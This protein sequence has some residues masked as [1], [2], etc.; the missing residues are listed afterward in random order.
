MSA[1]EEIRTPAGETTVLA[2]LA[3]LRET[4][5]GTLDPADPVAASALAGLDAAAH[6]VAAALHG[7]AVPVAPERIALLHEAVDAARA[8]MLAARF[9]LVQGTDEDRLSR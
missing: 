1:V 2:T 8:T 5:G 6:L 3:R 9:A 7:P 4:L